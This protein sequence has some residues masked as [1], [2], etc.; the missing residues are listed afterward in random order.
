MNVYTIVCHCALI[1]ALLGRAGLLCWHNLN[2]RTTTPESSAL[3][4]ADTS[5][6][7]TMSAFLGK[8][9]NISS[10]SKCTLYC[11]QLHN[12][13]VRTLT[14]IFESLFRAQQRKLVLFYLKH[15]SIQSI[16]AVLDT[17]S[18]V[19]LC[20][21]KWVSQMGNQFFNILH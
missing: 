11:R 17:D 2:L 10:I 7:L 21:Y 13:Q 20:G 16:H 9:V 18:Q 15:Q 14:L 12:L 5:P 19:H 3:C 1:L 6:C 4:L 8:L